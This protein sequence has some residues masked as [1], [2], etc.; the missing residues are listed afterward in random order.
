[1][2]RFLRLFLFL[3]IQLLG[4][5]GAWRAARRVQVPA[6]LSPRILLIRPDHLGDMV[7][8]TPIPHA[9]KSQV[10]TAHVTMMVGPWSREMMARHPAIDRLIT[11][12]FPK[13][14]RVPKRV[15]MPYLLLWQAA[16]RL[17]QEQYDVAI[18]L[19]VDYWW[20]SAL[21]YLAQIPRRVGYDVPEG[22]PFLTHSLPRPQREH[23]THSALHL[24]SLGL[25]AL[26]YAPLEEPYTP[27]CY[28]L[29][30]RPT[31]Q[32]RAWVTARLEAV[33]RGADETLVVIHP[34]TGSSIKL[35]QA[36]GWS[37]CADA[38]SQSPSIPGPIQLLLTGSPQER[39]LLEEIAGRMKSR[40]VIITDT[41]V[42]QLAAL[43]QRA[44]LVLGVDS[45]PLH[46]ATAQGTP[47]VRLFGPTDPAV[48][49]PWGAQQHHRVIA[50]A[51][52]CSTCTVIPCGRLD[53]CA[54]TEVA[55]HPC[56]RL[57]QE[58]DVL[59]A[60]NDLND[61]IREHKRNNREQR[62]HPWP[63][64]PLLDKECHKARK[65][66]EELYFMRSPATSNVTEA[67]T[68][69]QVWRRDS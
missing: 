40:P 52:R 51:Y 66:E 30:F 64:R 14:L 49:G 63:R 69:S 21:I 24:A 9:L 45:G 5:P 34:G 16:H 55:R 10:P 27:V 4:A 22:L 39:P 60:V 31:A 7:M 28:P 33:G 43:L 18:N 6:P 67:R 62:M 61:S 12:R 20:A 1:M 11:C 17:R 56:A 8:M 46:L 3:L 68:S 58:Q 41:T 53:I 26:G 37:R 38:I 29:A 59:V 57:I 54:P 36:E 13:L 32:E 2:R 44:D 15:V 50:S 48:F 42:G 65:Q 25:Q 47:T 35:W 19:R 23:T